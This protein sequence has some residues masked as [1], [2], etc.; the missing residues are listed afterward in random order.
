MS[1]LSWKLLA[2]SAAAVLGS[3]QSSALPDAIKQLSRYLTV[4]LPIKPAAV[5]DVWQPAVG[6]SWQ[7]VLLGAVD[8]QGPEDITPDVDIYDLD[9][10]DNDQETFAMLQAA[11]KK[12][13]C[14]FSAGSWED[15]RDDKDDF[16]DEDLGKELDGWPD[17]R[18][19]DLTSTNVR[20]IM[21]R[22][23]QVAA[24]KGC[25]AIDPDNVD[26]Y[27]NDNGLGLTHQDSIDFVKFLSRE[28]QARGMSIGLKN[29]G[30]IIGSV[31]GDVHFSVNEQCVQY[32]ECETFAAFTDAGKPVFHI[33]Y[34]EGAPD[35]SDEDL[36]R[37]CSSRGDAAGS[38]EFSKVIKL[39]DVDGW[40]KYCDG[41]E[42]TTPQ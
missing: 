1:R 33:E 13:I 25:D 6:A 23:I 30:E 40:V 31:L 28:V 36:A 29:A 41:N 39:M 38:G 18:W 37:I 12:V 11:G 27:N 14:Y 10:F 20:N 5:A 16:N 2:V 32:Q 8:L 24:D 7:I 15:W 9:L 21:T 34:P 19:L 3:A 35:V 22:R 17:E 4:P 26:G 42:Y